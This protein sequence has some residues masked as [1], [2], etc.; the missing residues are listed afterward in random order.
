M[1]TQCI[2]SDFTGVRNVFF[3]LNEH[4]P[5]V[6]KVFAHL[7]ELLQVHFAS[8]KFVFMDH[9]F[10]MDVIFQHGFHACVCAASVNETQESKAKA[11]TR[12]L[13]CS[14]SICWP[15]TPTVPPFPT[16]TCGIL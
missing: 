14:S 6:F 15:K 12:F 9:K 5:L 1:Y 10:G 2:Y 4:I 3:T 11:G 16:G 8:I 7:A 13:K